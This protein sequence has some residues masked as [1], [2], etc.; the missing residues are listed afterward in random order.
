MWNARE[1]QWEPQAGWK[2]PVSCLF[3][4]FCLL[5]GFLPSFPHHPQIQICSL[6][7][8]SQ[9]QIFSKRNENSLMDGNTVV[10]PFC[11]SELEFLVRTRKDSPKRKK[12]FRLSWMRLFTFRQ[13]SRKDHEQGQSRSRTPVLVLSAW[14]EKGFSWSLW[15]AFWEKKVTN[16]ECVLAKETVRIFMMNL[17]DSKG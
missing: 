10:L 5:L 6:M 11:F 14:Q 12:W 2:P 15:W 16:S 9:I 4:L 7:G 3:F 13:I 1:C 8:L 17:K